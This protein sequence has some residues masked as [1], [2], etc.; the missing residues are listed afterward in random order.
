M[1]TF[2][3][4]LTSF[5]FLVLAVEEKPNVIEPYFLELIQEAENTELWKKC[6]DI[7]DKKTCLSQSLFLVLLD[8]PAIDIILH[9]RVEQM[10]SNWLLLGMLSLK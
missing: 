5:L 10:V 7:A 6:S 4:F 2:C 1:K 3:F 8:D 9:H